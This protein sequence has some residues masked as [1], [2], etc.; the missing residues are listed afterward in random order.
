M[1][2]YLKGKLCGFILFS[3]ILLEIFL[4]TGCGGNQTEEEPVLTWEKVDGT[5]RRQEEASGEE[6]AAG[7]EA[8]KEES[9][10]GEDTAADDSGEEEAAD[11][12]VSEEE[13]TIAR[14]SAADAEVDFEA[15]KKE[16]PDIFAW[17][18]VPGTD[19]DCP[20]LQSGLADDYYESHDA[21]GKE[22][23]KGAVYTEMA[24]LMDMTDFNTVIHGKAN[25][26]GNFEDLYRY[27]DSDFFETNEEIYLYLEGNILV[28]E[29]FAAYEREDDSLI[30]RYN[31]AGAEGCE[32]FLKE[33]YTREI[34]KQIREGWEGLTPNHFLITLTTKAD[35][36]GE[37]QFVV[38]AALISD[39]AGT[40]NRE[41]FK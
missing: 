2:K 30:R 27:T 19:I 41:V 31:F 40:I 26:N 24:N 21:C 13:G 17:L 16:N 22:S 12:E 34:G 15:L 10:S 11:A 32:E 8:S 6:G 4:L 25:G 3:A 37:R 39:A 7:G 33:L 29:I 5:D 14:E 9:A 1:K 36:T 35:E 20:I 23:K 18:Y 28:Y 38:V